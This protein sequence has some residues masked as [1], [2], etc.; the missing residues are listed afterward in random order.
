M[1][2][3]CGFVPN[4]L[5]VMLT[6]G[7]RFLPIFPTRQ[8]Q[9]ILHRSRLPSHMI[10]SPRTCSPSRRNK[11]GC[12]LDTDIHTSAINSLFTS[13]IHSQRND[14]TFLDN[15]SLNCRWITGTLSLSV[16]P[17]F[18][19]PRPSSLAEVVLVDALL[20]Q[21]AHH[22]HHHLHAVAAVTP[23]PTR[24]RHSPL[25]VINS[26]SLFIS[27]SHGSWSWEKKGKLLWKNGHKFA[28]FAR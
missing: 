19:S 17:N 9:K 20:H 21:P 3:D 7:L 22:H 5:S 2:W 18:L 24:S 28:C 16:S 23:E 4:V 26:N 14:G 12:Q 25:R 10:F 27:V 13:K 8:T 6:S 11:A 1:K 15:A